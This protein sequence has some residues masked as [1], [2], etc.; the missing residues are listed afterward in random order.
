M[1]S[2]RAWTTP[3]AY[4]GLAEA[5][6]ARL[7]SDFE[8]TPSTTRERVATVDLDARIATLEADLAAADALSEQRRQEAEI[9]INRVADL[10]AHIATLEAAYAAAETRVRQLQ[11]ENDSAAK[12]IDE[13]VAEL[14]KVTGELV[15]MSKR[16]A[17]QMAVIDKLRAEFDDHRSRAWWWEHGVG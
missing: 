13:L 15:E 10:E 11:E 14:C 5:L 12:R 6:Q 1:S 17:E 3:M 4:P 8:T 2:I 9:A 16:M 7:R